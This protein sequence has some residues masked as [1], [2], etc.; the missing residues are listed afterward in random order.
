MVAQRLSPTISAGLAAIGA[1]DANVGFAGSVSFVLFSGRISAT[2]SGGDLLV[3]V[4]NADGNDPTLLRPAYLTFP[5]ADVAVGNYDVRPITSPLFLLVPSGKNLGVSTNNTP[6]GVWIVVFDD[7]GVLR[8]GVKVASNSAALISSIV[9]GGL[10]TSDVISNGTSSYQYYTNAVVS[11]KRLRLIGDIVW[12]SGLP[13]AGVWSSGPSATRLSIQGSQGP[14][15]SFPAFSGFDAGSWTTTSLI[16]FDDTIPQIGEGFDIGVIA[17]T[18]FR[19]CNIFDINILVNLSHSVASEI[20]GALFV[21]GG[22]D[23]IA[24]DYAYVSS[25]GKLTQI[26]LR[27]RVLAGTLS[28]R[29]YSVR[30]GASQA[31]T[32][33]FNGAGGSRKLGGTLATIFNVLELAG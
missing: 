8:L 25:A 32:T 5:N 1:V 17:V 15:A 20:V 29:N 14:G 27:F 31:G 23:A 9:D 21:D 6:F 13:S 2:V 11:S 7:G 19:A 16:P 22:A 30:V 24:T 26:V 4:K 12:N 3:A 33:T 28:Q 10:A 18:A